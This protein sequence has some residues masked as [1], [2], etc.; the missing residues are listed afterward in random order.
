MANY[1]S[2]A[3]WNSQDGNVTTVGSAG[4]AS[5]YGTF[6]Q[7]GNVFELTDTVARLLGE[8]YRVMRGGAWR[9]GVDD[10]SASARLNLIPTLEFD[11]VGF[12]V[13]SVPEP[14]AGLLAAFGL[15][16]VLL[17]RRQRRKR[18]LCERRRTV[19]V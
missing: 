3:D 19:I 9:L 6:D 4:S 2:S 17:F 8:P 11:D 12:R 18:G 1:G 15:A 10:L 5:F 7:G 16:G 14:H 13:A